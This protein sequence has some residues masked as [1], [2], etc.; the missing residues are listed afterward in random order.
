MGTDREKEERREEN[1]EGW[2]AIAASIH[3]SRR[4]IKVGAL[5]CLGGSDDEWDEEEE[6]KEGPRC[7]STSRELRPEMTRGSD[8]YRRCPG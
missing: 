8:T 2:L 4:A 1:E 3:R 7:T 6:H 5:F